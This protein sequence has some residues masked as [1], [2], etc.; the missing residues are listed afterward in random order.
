MSSK[1][2][3]IARPLSF[4]LAFGLIG[5]TAHGYSNRVDFSLSLYVPASC[6]ITS[7]A[8]SAAPNSLDVTANCNAEYFSI[9]LGGALDQARILEVN[10]VSAVAHSSASGFT[11]H[12][13]RPGKH[14]FTLTFEEP[15]ATDDA[16]SAQIELQ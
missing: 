16:I 3:I 9:R 7:I 15:I 10:S 6:A 5:Q 4:L 12:A 1:L 8:P 11:A 14:N 2:I 13:S